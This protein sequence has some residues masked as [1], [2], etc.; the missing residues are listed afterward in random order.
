MQSWWNLQEDCEDK[1]TLKE[2]LRLLGFIRQRLITVANGSQEE[3][4]L[5]KLYL[6]FDPTMKRGLTLV[7]LA[8]VCAK[9]AIEADEKQL[10][11]LFA[12]LDLNHNGVIDFDEFNYFIVE[13]AYK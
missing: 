11:G 10:R 8:G 5:R 13:D 6:Q 9:L 7:E 3:Y 1:I 2:N 12:M 4:A